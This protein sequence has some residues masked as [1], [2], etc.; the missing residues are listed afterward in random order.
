MFLIPIRQAQRYFGQ[1]ISA[2]DYLFDKGIAH[3]DLKPENIL[4]DDADNLKLTDFGMATLFKH[5]DAERKLTKCC[6][7]LPY[8]A[9]EVLRGGEFYARPADIW[10]CGIILVAMLAGELPWDA[11]CDTNREFADWNDHKVFLYSQHSY[12]S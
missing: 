8:V 1:L 3:R 10:S 4:L 11:P 9:P 5:K 2:V 12:D 6:G 7:T